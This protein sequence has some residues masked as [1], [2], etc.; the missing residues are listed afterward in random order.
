MPKINTRVLYTLLTAIII[1]VGTYFA[2]RYAQGGFRVTNQGFVAETGLLSANSF[3]TGAEV[4][5]N[6]KLS[7]ATDDTL[8]LE[9]GSYDVEIVK[10]GYSPWRKTLQ[11]EKELVTQT[12]ALLFPSAPSLSPLT[13]TGVENVSP[14]PDGQKLI[15][16]T[17]SAS[18]QTKN[19][20]Y[21]MDL[22]N[23]LNPLQRGS[24]QLA[25]DS[26]YFQ[27]DAAKFIWSPDSSQ[28][29]IIDPNH[30]VLL[31]VNR[32]TDLNTLPDIRLKR[33]QILS[34]WE[35]EMYLRER[36]FLG[37]FPPEIIAIA[38]QSAKNVYISPDKKRLMY[39]ATADITIPDTIVPPLPA[40]NTQPEK[41][42]LQSGE[43]YVY[44]REEDKNFYLGNESDLLANITST[45]SAQAQLFKNQK[46]LLATDLD[47]EAKSLESSPSA[48]QTLQATTSAQTADN[49]NRYHTSLFANTMQWFPDSKHIFYDNKTQIRVMEYDAT[50]L[51]TLYS[52]PFAKNFIYPW[53]DG[54][55]LIILTSFSPDS[56]LNLYAIEL[57]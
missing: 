35:E 45:D 42:Q 34:E 11:I 29:M 22:S 28:I 26:N 13:F 39:T 33:K 51:T 55:K 40:S 17:A 14:S 8:Y 46:Y 53:P 23:S 7:T 18:S 36:E 52:G 44:D 9:P 21:V 38:T 16:Y 43:I 57:K 50:N 41:R 54:S 19:G 6:G 56:P 10:D 4:H 20:L 15:Y 1:G 5:I 24:R 49:F 37:K 25:E 31:D 3:P 27:L 12:N 30:E 2:I 47:Q 48:F 32:Q